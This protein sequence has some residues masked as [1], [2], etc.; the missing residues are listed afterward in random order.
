[1]IVVNYDAFLP[2]DRDTLLKS[3]TEQCKNGRLL[4]YSQ[5]IPHEDLGVLF[6]VYGL[7]NL[8]AHNINQD[9]DE[10]LVTIQ[11]IIQN[12]IFGIKKY[13]SWASKQKNYEILSTH[14]AR[15]FIEEAKQFAK[16][17]GI[18]SRLAESYV[19]VADE[20]VMNA[21]YNAPTDK[22]SE[23]RYADM[24][25]SQ[26]VVLDVD[27][28]IEAVL[29]YDGHRLGISVAD[30][31]GSLRANKVTNYLAKC[32]RNGEQQVSWDTGGAGL[33]LYQA[34]NALSHFVI[35]LSCN[36]RTEIIGIVDVRGSYRDFIKRGKS[37]NIFV[38]NQRRNNGYG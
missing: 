32:F 2:E 17:V 5:N 11:K 22:K 28:K 4:I 24:A 10:F 38:E 30:S 15:E 9:S 25:R 33:G 8:L 13:F 31:F 16:E 27:E 3:L 26:E 19:I 21:V 34:Y 6:G 29:C 14:D 18:P 23:P 20:L 35:N 36:K 1:M 7:T 37:F 12:D